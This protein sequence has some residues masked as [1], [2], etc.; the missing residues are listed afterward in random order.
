MTH[1]I[2]ITLMWSETFNVGI[3]TGTPVEDDYQVQFKSTGEIDQLTVGLG[4]DEM[5]RGKGDD[6]RDVPSQAIGTG[7]AVWMAGNPGQA[8]CRKRTSRSSSS[9]GR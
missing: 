6:F 2:P 5:T 4:P 8:A 7:G 3:D 1:S 9:L